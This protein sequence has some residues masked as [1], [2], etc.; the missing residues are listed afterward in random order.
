LS[1]KLNITR[2]DFLNGIALSAAAG[3]TVS[4]AE[5][6]AMASRSAGVYPPG[7]TGLRGSHPGSFE[8][9][10]AVAWGGASWP[11]PKSLTDDIYD[12]IVVGGG[13]SGLSAAFMYRQQM[14]S[15]AKILVID[16]HDDFGGHAK[17]NEFTVDGKTLIGYGGSQSIDTPGDYSAASTKL[18]RDI[19]IDT[20][21]F[22]DL[23]DREFSARHKLKNG[24]YF[25]AERYGED[26]V[27]TNAT[28]AF[29]FSGDQL[30]NIVNGYPL[31]PESK[32]SYIELA[33]GTADY[34]SG[35]SRSEKLAYLRSISY[36]NY[37]HEHAGST[38]QVVVLLRDIVKGY[39][40]IG[41]DALSALEAY[42]LGMPG[43]SGLGLGELEGER[44][45]A[46]EPY[47]FHFPDGN[48]GVARALVRHLLPEA[49]PGHTMDDLVKARVDYQRLDELGSATRI[50]VNSTAVDVRH[51]DGD[52]FVDVTYV[53]EGDAERVR[54]RHVIMACYNNIIPHICPDVS[55]AQ[56]E[57]IETAEKIP[58]VYISIAVRN[59]LPFANLGYQNFYIP[60]GILMHS[61][62]L[63][64]P[65]S[66][67]GYKFTDNP[68]QATIVHGTYVPTAPGQGLSEREQHVAGR[69]A[70]YEKSFADFERDIVRQLDGAL[71]GG[72]F[73]PERD[74]AAITVN[75]WP[76]GYAYEYNE[77][78]DPP[79]WSRESGPHIT[80]AQQMGRISI[81]NSDAA[82]YA[83]V[84]G[85]IDAAH[86]A[87]NEQI[88]HG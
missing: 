84:D 52:Q 82:A 47:I 55:A 60:D 51:S 53:R 75:R 15:G 64:F 32:S 56:R 58:L 26:S 68:E 66:M 30:A 13:I 65:V 11:Q 25:S 27:H 76:H 57:A 8:V 23:F 29:G 45:G 14:G 3:A 44:E 28:R 73:D 70:L 48:A 6:L 20:D 77:L 2:R 72:G 62:G 34:L 40:G 83:Y 59:W 37:L 81:A 4:P 10:H 12:L 21:R 38:E 36:T 41:F 39:W 9:S 35:K 49:V 7:L 74:I 24:I 67:G 19:S 69:R 80:G 54:G 43:L 22:Y 46:D 31:T 88:K 16:N 33:T 61:F 63:D 17:R 86:R 78:F 79:E 87:V 42:R 5:L 18:L 71:A 1:N 50:R 85:A